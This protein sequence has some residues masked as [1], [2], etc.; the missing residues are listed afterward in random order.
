MATPKQHLR[1]YLSD[2]SFCILTGLSEGLDSAIMCATCNKDIVRDVKRVELIE[3]LLFGVLKITHEIYSHMKMGPQ[4]FPLDQP[5]VV[6]P[7][8]EVGENKGDVDARLREALLR[9]AKPR[10]WL[11]KL[12]RQSSTTAAKYGRHVRRF[13]EWLG[14]RHINQ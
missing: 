4:E 3:H 7:D 9:I 6:V 5:S 14:V 12:K 10:D 13:E 1:P 11:A 8:A 2:Q